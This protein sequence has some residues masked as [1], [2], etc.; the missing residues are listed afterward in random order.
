MRARAGVNAAN[1]SYCVS[2]HGV[3]FG[4][5]NWR[6]LGAS[7]FPLAGSAPCERRTHST[8]K[9]YETRINVSSA[10][11][12]KKNVGRGPKGEERN[13]EDRNGEEITK[14]PA[15]SLDPRGLCAFVA[16]SLL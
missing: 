10:E 5:L 15:G 12:K 3:T 13:S 11:F 6:P 16:S 7:P 8:G 9:S 1:P 2:R 4:G 14:E